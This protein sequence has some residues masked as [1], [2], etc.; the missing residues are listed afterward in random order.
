MLTFDDGYRDVLWHAAPVL[1]RLHM[2]ATEYV[3]T[4]RVGGPDP[5]FLT[6]QEL[7]RL[8]HFG[9]EIGSHT[10]H[11]LKLPSLTDGQALAELEGSRRA[12][13][14][15]LGHPVQWFSY[16]VGAETPHAAA[17]VEQAG[18]VLA[19]GTQP[20]FVQHASA[21]LDLHRDEIQGVTGIVRFAA[22]VGSSRAVPTGR[23]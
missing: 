19:V 5:S 10:V 1:A 7:R 21:P 4:G 13:E 17:L 20:G 11:H 3:I 15:H 16:P 8:E 6:W 23:G 14:R 9:F 2:P 18:Y 12:L 22:I